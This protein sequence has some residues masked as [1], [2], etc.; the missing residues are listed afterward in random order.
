[1]R[2]AVLHEA[3]DPPVITIDEITDP[4]VGPD[5]VLIRVEACGL[6]GH[7]Q[8]DALGL[9]AIPIP[10]V[11]GHEIA[12]VVSAVGDGATSLAVG[13][14]VATRMFQTC[15][16]CDV[17]RSDS[18]LRCAGRAF[19]YGGL[20]DYVVCGARSVI[21]IPDGVDSAAASI[22]GCAIGTVLQAAR[23]VAKI[24]PDEFV[25]ITGATGGLGLHA[26]Q[27]ARALGARPIALTGSTGQTDLLRS[28]GAEVVIDS[29]QPD[30]W[31]A[32]LEAT[33][34]AGAGVVIDNVGVPDLFTACFRGLAHGGRYVFTGQVSRAKISLY[35]KFLFSKEAIV[36]GSAGVQMSTMRDAMSMVEQGLITPVTTEM[37]R[38]DIA[39]ALQGLADRTT[40]G[41]IVL[42]P[43]TT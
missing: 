10:A 22:V 21:R 32:L 25:G 30:S 39:S 23:N 37:P 2:A 26:V 35:P 4:S 3:G 13:D 43:T 7:D 11:L 17:C 19:L 14:R 40:V 28:L 1:M 20:A 9:A 29:R 41:R 33:G 18:D 8:A 36:T 24:R 38:Q 27:V 16:Q 15:G 6:C 31:R 42:T 5:D 34:G 12:G